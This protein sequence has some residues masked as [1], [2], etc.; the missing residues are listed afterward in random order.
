MLLHQHPCT[1]R[2]RRPGSKDL[3]GST[4]FR[5]SQSLSL[6]PLLLS[7][8][9]L[10]LFLSYVT[11]SLEVITPTTGGS[12]ESSRVTCLKR[13]RILRCP[14]SSLPKVRTRGREVSR[15]ARLKHP[16][17]RIDR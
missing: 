7:R 6:L 5:A 9:A 13:A 15:T 1:P 12:P 17:C 10:F 4:N 2:T 14:A 8:S 11:N 16:A 3:W